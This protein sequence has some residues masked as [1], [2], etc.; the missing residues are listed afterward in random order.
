[1]TS[2]AC[3]PDS[4]PF[5]NVR[6]DAGRLLARIGELARIGADHAGG[7]TRLAFSPEDVQARDLVAGWMASSGLAVHVDPVG[8]LLGRLS[9]TGRHRAAL[10]IGSHLD[11]VLE[12]GALDGAYGVLAALEVADALQRAG[13]RLGHDLVVTAF[14]GEEGGRGTPGM[15][16]SSAVA[17][18]LTPADLASTDDEGVPLATRIADA[19]G[20]PGRIADAAWD[21]A[22]V[23]GYVELHIEQGPVLES[24]G[25]PVGVVTAITGQ[26]KVDVTITG[27]ANHAG[28]TPM[29]RRRDAAVAA[30]HLVLAVESLAAAG[31]VHA[32]TTGVL[33]AKPGVRNVVPGEAVLGID[34]R[35]LDRD[36]ISAAIARLGEAAASV[37]QRTGTTI[38]LRPGPAV[39]SVPTAPWLAGCVAEAAD[40][41]GAPHQ[42]LPSGAGHDAQIMARL[43]PVAMIFVPSLGGVSHSPAEASTPDDLVLGADV[44]LRTV[45]MADDVL[46]RRRGPSVS[47]HSGAT[48]PRQVDAVHAPRR[49]ST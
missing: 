35:D 45:V 3:D 48:T 19:G 4:L 8:N 41:L 33:A 17:G 25:C 16:G 2:S 27:T 28:T 42:E 15:V 5:P 23:A 18:L 14:S 49:S 12:G 37:A 31:H 46:Y 30:A 39:P 9:G 22:D 26:A 20:D 34:I 11:T 44:L 40:A 13:T 32:A 1:M 7:V 10:V 43:G 24:T 29:D 36:R 47:S 38:P 6:V 21:P